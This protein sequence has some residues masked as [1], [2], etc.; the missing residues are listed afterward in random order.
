MEAAKELKVLQFQ[1]REKTRREASL[2]K[3]VDELVDVMRELFL[4]EKQTGRTGL[5]QRVF[6][7]FTYTLSCAMHLAGVKS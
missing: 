4:V 1:P 6:L 7:A 3:S 5:P 2:D